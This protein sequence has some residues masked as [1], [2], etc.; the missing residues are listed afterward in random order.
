MPNGVRSFNCRMMVVGVPC[1]CIRI[2]T[3]SVVRQLHVMPKYMH[4]NGS[5]RMDCWMCDVYVYYMKNRKYM[6]IEI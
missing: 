6:G 4:M 5:V 2:R 3:L 1:V